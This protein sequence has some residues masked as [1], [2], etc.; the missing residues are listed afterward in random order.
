MPE[1]RERKKAWRQLAAGMFALIGRDDRRS[2]DLV[3][4]E[5]VR[6]YVFEV[7]ATHLLG[8]AS[9]ADEPDI[10]SFLR[11]WVAEGGKLAMPAWL[12]SS[13]MRLH[14]VDNLDAQLRPG[15]G[16][17]LEPTEDRPEVSEEELDL[18]ITPGRFF[19]E[20]CA[21]M[22]RGSGCY[23]ALFKRRGIANIGVAYD[24]QVFPELP[25]TEKDV[26]VD[27]VIT[28]SRIIKRG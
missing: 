16:G 6:E 8:F 27:L 5:R 9:M 7:G 12:G 19:S 10:S 3:L 23:D 26:P 28:P 13:R 15:R 1:V 20:R 4:A 2:L 18:V 14:S 21:R 17:I 25:T 11:Q 24:F 22:G